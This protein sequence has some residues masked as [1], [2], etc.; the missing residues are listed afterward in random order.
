MEATLERVEELALFEEV[1]GVNE[2]S[3][4]IFLLPGGFEPLRP[5]STLVAA[6]L[7]AGTKRTVCRAI[8]R[9]GPSS[10]DKVCETKLVGLVP[11]IAEA[12]RSRQLGGDSRKE[13]GMVRDNMGAGQESGVGE[14]GVPTIVDEDPI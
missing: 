8:G 3:K 13:E 7:D 9:A 11:L 14:Q 2:G 6:G 10:G 5:V 1:K 4:V 12:R